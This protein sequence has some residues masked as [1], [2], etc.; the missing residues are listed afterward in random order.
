MREYRDAHGA[1][2]QAEVFLQVLDE[3]EIGEEKMGYITVFLFTKDEGVVEL[4]IK[5]VEELYEEEERLRICSE[6][7][8]GRILP[9]D[10]D[11]RWNS[12]LMML[13]AAIDLES[14]IWVFIDK[15]WDD[16]S[17]NSLDHDE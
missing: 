16:M 15:N 2:E 17:K 14:Y 1:K 13:E 10:N 12:W 11:T 8:A 5:A 7:L 6:D 9:R 4:A 3:Y